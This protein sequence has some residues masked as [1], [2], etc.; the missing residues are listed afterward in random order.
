MTDSSKK[1]IHASC[2]QFLSKGLLIVGPSASGK[3]DLALRL[4]DEGARLV[5]DDQVEISV[6]QD[7]SP[8]IRAQAPERIQ[9][10][11][12][13][14]GYGIVPVPFEPWT[15]LDLVIELK[16]FKELERLSYL[17]SHLLLDCS[18]PKMMV[19]AAWPSSVSRIKVVLSMISEKMTPQSFSNIS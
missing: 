17:H 11:I 9:G 15:H 3:S 14:R 12:E 2:V 16:P 13:L 10:L 1:I 7:P 19:D 5:S 18:L 4:M 8:R 6:V